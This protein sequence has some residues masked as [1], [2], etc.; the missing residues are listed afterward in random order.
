MKK[1][2]YILV[3]LFSRDLVKGQWMVLKSG[4]TASFTKVSFPSE[5]I[6]FAITL[7][8]ILHTSDGGLTWQWA[9][10]PDY[11]YLMAIHF[12]SDS[13]GWIGGG[14]FPNGFV[15][16]TRD[17]GKTWKRQTHP[18]KQIGSVYFID[19]TTGW[20][21]GNDNSGY[22]LYETTD[23]GETWAAKTSGSDYLRTVF[24]N[25]Q[26]S[27][28]VVGDNGH[29]LTTLDEGITWTNQ[30]KNVAFHF[31]DVFVVSNTIAYAVGAFKYGGCYKTIDGGKT[32]QTQ[33]VPTLAYLFSVYFITPE[34]GWI[35]G[36]RGTILKTVDGGK[37]WIQQTTNTTEDL[38]GIQFPTATTGYAVGMNGILLKLISD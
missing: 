21:I 24:F 35:A 8:N 9:K 17:G 7:S 33:S 12:I 1:I 28:W 2:F 29:I 18:I 13:V 26:S 11:G 3:I 31:K 6:G 23:G 20:A 37:N 16:R 30:N 14:N 10:H 22:T 4:T 27:G 15:S 5:K 32:W 36:D 25:S 38:S 19:E 34:T